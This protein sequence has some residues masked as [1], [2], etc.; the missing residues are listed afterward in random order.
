[1][2]PD[3]YFLAPADIVRRAGVINSSYRVA[4]GRFVIT[5][6]T[7][8]RLQMRLTAE[9]LMHGLDI[10]EISATEARRLVEANNHQTGEQQTQ[11][12]NTE[13]ETE[14]EETTDGDE[15]SENVEEDESNG[16]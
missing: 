15:S 9:E 16:D 6:N 2:I 12:N 8:R 11:S 3:T 14:T 13:Q 5:A 7:L 1:M 4:D 10:E